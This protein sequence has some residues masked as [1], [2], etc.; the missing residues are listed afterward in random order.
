MNHTKIAMSQVGVYSMNLNDPPLGRGSFAT[1]RRA[2]NT[3]TKQE[4]AAKEIYCTQEIRREKSFS[5]YIEPELRSLQ[6]L[7][8]PYLV[9]FLH[10]E[11]TDCYLYIFLEYCEKGSLDSFV[12]R[13][14]LSPQLRSRFM[15]E[16]ADVVE[17][18]H[19]HD[20]IHRD[21]KPDNILVKEEDGSHHIR[22]ADLGV[23]KEVSNASEARTASFQGTQNWAAPQLHFDLIGQKAKYSNKADVFAVGLVY[24]A[25]INQKPGR[26]LK[27]LTGTRNLYI[28]QY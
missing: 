20:I 23:I 25:L 11:F 10:A 1:V 22:L 27:P 6:N 4:V 15:L 18:I 8:H 14:S 13:H 26:K 3:Q 12:K 2:L 5:K 16:L 17:Y 7:S 24:H 9:K 21:I 28:N 19:Q